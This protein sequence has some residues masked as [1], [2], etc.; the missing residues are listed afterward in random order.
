VVATAGRMGRLV[1]FAVVGGS[2]VVVSLLVLAVLLWATDLL[3]MP[4]EYA[5]LNVSDSEATFDGWAFLVTYR[6][7]RY[8]VG[9]SEIPDA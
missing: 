7:A 6:C 5:G 4:P 8:R 1:R 9:C 3:S 2:G